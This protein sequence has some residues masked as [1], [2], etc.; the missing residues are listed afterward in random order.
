MTERMDV[1][2]PSR[3]S[4]FSCSVRIVA[5]PEAEP[6]YFPQV[7]SDPIISFGTARYILLDSSKDSASG[8]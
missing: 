3:R 8:P 7:G 4:A 2:R 1:Q 6:D 5:N